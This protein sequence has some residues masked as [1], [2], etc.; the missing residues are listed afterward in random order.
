[1][2]LKNEH[3]DQLN[4]A[5]LARLSPVGG[6]V[7]ISHDSLDDDAGDAANYPM[8]FLNALNPAGAPPHELDLRIGSV[9]MIVRNIDK[10]RGLCNGTRCVLIR[11]SKKLLD[12]RVLTGR[13]QGQRVFIPRMKISTETRALPCKLSRRQFPVRF[14]W[15]LTMN[16]AQGQTLIR[17]GLFLPT[18]V[19]AHG[20]L[21]VGC[22]RVGSFDRLMVY[23][24]ETEVQGWDDL[25]NGQRTFVTDNVVYDAIL[26]ELPSMSESSTSR[27]RTHS[28]SAAVSVSSKRQ[29]T[30]TA[31]SADKEPQKQKLSL[32]AKKKTSS[33][34]SPT[35]LWIGS[36]AIHLVHG[37]IRTKY[38][39]A[40]VANQMLHNAELSRPFSTW[41]TSLLSETRLTQVNHK[42]MMMLRQGL[43]DHYPQFSSAPFL[44]WSEISTEHILSLSHVLSEF[45]C[46]LYFGLAPKDDN[47]Y[48]N[49]RFPFFRSRLPLVTQ[50]SKA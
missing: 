19:F 10:P 42:Y 1:M 15:A 6:V 44:V 14:A 37:T 30:G 49:D 16:K 18:P 23:G 27:K 13:A 17:A 20:Q 31:G 26:R 50:H 34:A 9:L 29:K 24:E 39:D 3:V 7:S 12:V 22:S 11:A 35:V 40:S 2:C 46:I 32:F 38:L 21:Y 48:R 47:H 36:Y 4:A 33:R 41:M 45:L 43:I 28:A 25:E 8:E 5:L